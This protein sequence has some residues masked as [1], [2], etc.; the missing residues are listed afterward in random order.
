MKQGRN[1]SVQKWHNRI[2]NGVN[3]LKDLNIKVADKAIVNQMAA[4]NGRAG[5]PIEADHEAAEERSYAVRFIRGS[6]FTDYK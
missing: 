6:C 2:H 4:V 1:Q 5:E 3:I